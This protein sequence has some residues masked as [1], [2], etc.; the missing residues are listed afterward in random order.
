V[1]RLEKE[2]RDRGFSFDKTTKAPG[3][4]FKNESTGEE[5]RIMEKPPRAYRNDPNE[6]HESDFYYRYR[7]SVNDPDGVA[8]SIPNKD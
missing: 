3:K 6:K 2:L 5:I 1:N 4:L 8:V 7:K